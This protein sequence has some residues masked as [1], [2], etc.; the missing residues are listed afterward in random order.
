[1]P[2]QII[3]SGSLN[4]TALVVP[5]AYIQITPPAAAIAGSPSNIA[6]VVGTA[7]WGPVNAP[8]T[9]GTAQQLQ[10]SF[11]TCQNR[12]HDISTVVL[13]AMLQGANNFKIVRV[14]DGT[15]VKAT[16]EVL[17]TC[18]GFT[19]YYSGTNGN[20]ITVSVAPGSL[21]ST[22][23]ATVSI[24]G[25]TPEIFD[26][27]AGSGNALWLA[28]AA[29]INLGIA[30]VR[31]P[32]RLI[33]AVAGAGTTAPATAIYT[34]VGGT[35]GVA[36]VTDATLIGNPAATPRSGMYALTGQACS[37][38][39]LADVTTLSTFSTQSAFGAQQAAYMIAATA[40][41]D[42]L[43]N[44]A[45]DMATAAIPLAQAPWIKVLFGD[46]CY[47]SDPVNQINRLISPQGFVLGLLA[48]MAPQNSALNVG[49]SG[50]TGTQSTL[51]QLPYAPSDIQLLVAAGMD[52]VANPSP[53]GSYFAC[54]TGHN[55]SP[56]VQNQTD[57]YT[58]MTNYLATSYG[59]VAGRW[60]GGGNLQSIATNDP[61]RRKVKTAFDAFHESL[62]GAT[63]PQL[64]SASTVCDLTNNTPS[65][66]ALGY[67]QVNVAAR[68]LSVVQFFI[69]NLLGGQSV[70][71]AVANTVPVGP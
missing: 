49:L 57:N 59:A 43:A 17:S 14:T 55:A 66:I 5:G 31:G 63:P 50:I 27:I 23:K 10:Q 52:L 6:G 9:I 16:I 69:V 29:A 24:P 39:A 1:M 40:A 18:I 51:A 41:S 12:V 70:T 19:A 11:G 56:A 68:Y 8:I 30:G 3:P 65:Q 35:D 2:A 58:M 26:N 61:W 7:N 13:A 28:M 44:A 42:T 25:Q 20:L 71:V 60:V 21:A 36:S 47:W 37:K 46:W 64:D 22:F 45:T 33:T 34:L 54:Q 38:I 32:S 48:N 4:P 53:G 15:D 62:I 67:A